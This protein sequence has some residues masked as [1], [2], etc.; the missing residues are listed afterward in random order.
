MY[1]EKTGELKKYCDC[2]NCRKGLLSVKNED[3][4]LVSGIIGYA[5]D[6][7][8]LGGILGGSLLGGILGDSVDGDLFD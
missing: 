4:T 1:C 6:S 3:S 8:L 7:A 5:T 2:S